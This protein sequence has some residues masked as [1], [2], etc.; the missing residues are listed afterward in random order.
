MQG[1]LPPWANQLRADGA[2]ERNEL[3]R[4]LLTY[5][6]ADLSIERAARELFVHPNTIRYRLRR[7]STLTGLDVRRF[8]DLVELVTAV[9]LL[10]VRLR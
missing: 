7:L 10:P 3:V 8:F 5:I 6:A 1:R 9:R 2:P 4:T